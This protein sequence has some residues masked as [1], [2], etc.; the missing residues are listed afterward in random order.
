[1]E[2]RIMH[3][4][5]EQ[6]SYAMLLLEIILVNLIPREVKEKVMLRGEKVVVDSPSI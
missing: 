1:M 3:R 5:L 2:D 4:F 6:N